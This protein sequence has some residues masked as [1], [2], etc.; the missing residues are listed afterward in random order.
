MFRFIL[1]ILSIFILSAQFVL[2]TESKDL[3]DSEN[4][5]SL[6]IRTTFWQ[7]SIFKTIRE[8]EGAV[9][10]KNLKLR[11]KLLDLVGSKI[12]ENDFKELKKEIELNH[13][14]RRDVKVIIYP[15]NDDDLRIEISPE[16]SRS[17]FKKRKSWK[18]EWD[19]DW[20][21]LDFDTDYS[22]EKELGLTYSFNSFMFNLRETKNDGFA[23]GY[24]AESEHNFFRGLFGIRYTMSFSEFSKL[25]LG[26]GIYSQ[27]MFQF[28]W[29]KGEDGAEA[30]MSNG[31]LN[32]NLQVNPIHIIGMQLPQV[33]IVHTEFLS[34]HHMIR[35]NLGFMKSDP[36]FSDS[37]GLESDEVNINSYG[38]SYSLQYLDNRRFPMNG[39][40]TN[41]MYQ[42]NEVR[43]AD[44]NRPYKLGNDYRVNG[45]STG[46]YNLSYYAG[47]TAIIEHLD[48]AAIQINGQYL[49]QKY[50][51]SNYD[52]SFKQ[53]VNSIALFENKLKFGMVSLGLR[54][55]LG[56]KSVLLISYGQKHGKQEGF[57]SASWK[58]NF[59]E[60]M[61]HSLGFQ[62][63]YTYV[64]NNDIS[65]NNLSYI[66]RFYKS[67]GAYFSVGISF[68]SLF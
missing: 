16:R 39:I 66:D 56:S 26:S 30:T 32:P 48:G 19:E 20:G 1:F 42:Y 37:L 65:N 57:Q 3:T 8:L 10:I 59:I 67:E 46:N 33:S 41:F 61:Y 58:S 22:N 34:D 4:D 36:L 40:Y 38:F 2:T 54:Q 15:L 35:A 53:S 5:L 9:Y 28:D 50:N 60:A 18:D 24:S 7:D 47:I 52:G 11:R 23:I 62:F 68:G 63:K 49:E 17:R 45:Y 43:N 6:Q 51:Q 13:Q 27:G 64:F 31:R 55:K 44:K 14:Y 12:T 21:D 25:R 29:S